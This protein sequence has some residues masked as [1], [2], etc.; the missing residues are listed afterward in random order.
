MIL[1]VRLWNAAHSYSASRGVAESDEEA[2]LAP[3][4]VPF[5][6]WPSS[7]PLPE[8]PGLFRLLGPLLRGWPHIDK[9]SVA[10]LPDG[11]R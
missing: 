11:V 6:G 8:S 3:N 7:Q 10:M 2:S 1:P 5:S 9:E 4:I